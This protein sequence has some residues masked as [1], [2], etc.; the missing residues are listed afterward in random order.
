M[1]A[2]GLAHHWQRLVDEQRAASMAEIAEAEGMDVTQVRRVIRLTLLA[3]CTIE[4]LASSAA[5]SLDAVLRCE[6][7]G[8]TGESADIQA[9]F[10]AWLVAGRAAQPRLFSGA[11][12]T[13]ETGIE[14][15]SVPPPPDQEHTHSHPFRGKAAR[16][17][18]HRTFYRRII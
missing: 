13:P 18:G 14:P 11:S 12:S 16:G 6:K 7:R 2:F 5:V 8:L 15:A 3:P 9:G 4:R 1:W 17:A 10:S